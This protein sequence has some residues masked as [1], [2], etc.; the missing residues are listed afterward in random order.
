MQILKIQ[1]LI[2]ISMFSGVEID[3]DQPNEKSKD[4]QF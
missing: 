1:S 2:I 4:Y 3:E